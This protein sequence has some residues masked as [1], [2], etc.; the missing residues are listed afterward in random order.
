MNTAMT[1][2]PTTPNLCRLGAMAA[3]TMPNRRKKRPTRIPTAGC[4]S[5]LFRV[6]LQH[7]CVVLLALALGDAQRLPLRALPVLGQKDDLADVI[8]VVRK[9]A[10][11]GLQHR[12]RFAA[13]GDGT[14]QLLGMK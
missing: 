1:M 12:M 5:K 3:P 9:L 4:T 2:T 6:F 7:L 8:R 13:N 10:I 11:D 14:L